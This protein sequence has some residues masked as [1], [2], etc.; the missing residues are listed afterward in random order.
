MTA[1]QIDEHNFHCCLL[2]LKGMCSHVLLMVSLMH[3]KFVTG[4]F[5]LAFMLLPFVFSKLKNFNNFN[6]YRALLRCR[7]VSLNETQANMTELANQVLLKNFSFYSW[8]AQGYPL[9]EEPP[10]YLSSR[11]T[12]IRNVFFYRMKL[13]YLKELSCLKAF[14]STEIHWHRR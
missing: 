4:A 11:Y 2:H 8:H 6:F 1:S 14:Q 9:S 7:V 10:G 3:L 5:F 12:N 13:P